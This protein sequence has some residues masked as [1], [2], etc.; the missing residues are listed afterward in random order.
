[1]KQLSILVAVCILTVGCRPI[2]S[3]RP[4]LVAVAYKSAI[5]TVR[6]RNVG[7]S[8]DIAIQLK[9]GSKE[10]QAV[11]EH[12]QKDEERDVTLS[13]AGVAGGTELASLDVWLSN[14]WV[15]TLDLKTNTWVRA[16]R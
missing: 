4:E 10:I 3:P 7:A 5:V 8:G 12:F 13:V 14:G 2:E 1:M 6:I 15:A 16:A 11:T 9:T